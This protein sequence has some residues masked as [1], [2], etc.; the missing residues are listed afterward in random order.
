M[1]TSSDTFSSPGILG[2]PLFLPWRLLL[3]DG[4]VP[5]G[6]GQDSVI[7]DSTVM[8]PAKMDSSET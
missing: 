5:G 8:S 3:D 7:G 4:A 2:R 1:L 6:T